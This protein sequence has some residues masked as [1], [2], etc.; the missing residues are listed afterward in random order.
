MLNR[1]H[2][3]LKIV[4]YLYALQASNFEDT[5]QQNNN[6]F[7]S[8][9]SVFNL[10]IFQ[11]SFLLE[12]QKISKDKFEKSKKSLFGNVS[13]KYSSDKLSKNKFLQ[14]ISNQKK[15]KEIL[16]EKEFINWD[17]DYKFA[18]S[19]YNDLIDS[20][21]YSD[22]IVEKNFSIE[23]DKNFVKNIY[24]NIILKNTSFYSLIQQK[25]IFWTDDFALVNTLILKLI[26]SF[27]EKK[28]NKI[29]DA[30]YYSSSDD[31]KFASKLSEL[32]LQKFESNNLIIKELTPN[33]DLDRINKLDLVIINLGISE[34][35]NFKEIPKKVSINEYIE[36]SKDYSSEKSSLF[37]NGILDK[38]KK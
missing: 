14:K 6:L 19:V 5:K 34:I 20:K 37:I 18:N 26:N 2:I 12:I 16:N 1:R 25:N 23:T 22:Y 36:I 7:K 32:S 17:V 4:Q 35:L 31:E 10:F 27:S 38:I 3:R 13:L 29:L 8:L 24:K 28:F 33:W 15:F 21:I 11:I 30:K 9:E